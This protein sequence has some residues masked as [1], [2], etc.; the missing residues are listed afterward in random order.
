M[1]Y[2]IHIN[3]PPK[4]GN[5]AEAP[6]AP[7]PA[8]LA[9]GDRWFATQLGSRYGTVADEPLPADWGDLVARLSS[10]DKA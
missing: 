7:A 5:S 4:D 8:E 3:P 10:P 6:R 9:K 1:I 2:R